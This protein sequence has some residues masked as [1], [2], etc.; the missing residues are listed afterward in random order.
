MNFELQKPELGALRQGNM[1]VEGVWQFDSGQP[2]RSV[3]IMA[4]IH[5]NELCGAWALKALL[6]ANIR[7]VSGKLTLMFC[8]LEAFDSFDAANHDASRFVDEDMNRVWSDARLAH[9]D[10]Q[11]VHRAS[12]LLPFAQQADWLLDLHSMH[13]PGA[14]L[15]LTG[16]LPRNVALARKL[17]TPEHIVVDAGHKEGVRLRDY[18]RFGAADEADTCSLLIECGFHG[19]I[20]SPAV[21]LDMATRF[22]RAANCVAA[23]AFPLNWLQPLPAQQTALQVTHAVVAQSTELRFTQDWQ[24][25]QNIPTKGTVVAYDGDITF[26]TPYDHCT[27]IMPSLRQLRAGATVV[28]LAQKIP[29]I[30]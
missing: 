21:A 10:S 17:G 27:L 29:S 25:L 30:Q 14:P 12:A 24:D 8:N 22:L 20:T 4:L 2:G 28:R 7:P 26:A 13:E 23:D 16:L 5:G 1:G 15:L 11:E 3:L 6:E 18:G 19:D 9:P